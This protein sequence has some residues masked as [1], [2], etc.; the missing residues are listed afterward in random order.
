MSNVKMASINEAME[1]VTCQQA[2]P[3]A[4]DDSNA[5]SRKRPVDCWTDDSDRET[6]VLSKF[7]GNKCS[8]NTVPCSPP[9]S[10]KTIV[11]DD[12]SNGQVSEHGEHSTNSSHE[13]GLLEFMKDGTTV[14]EAA[15]LAS[16]AT[17]IDNVIRHFRKSNKP[18]SGK[19]L[20]TMKKA[21]VTK[22]K[23]QKLNNGIETC[24]NIKP[25]HTSDQSA[26]D[27]L[28]KCAFCHSIEI[29]DLTGPMLHYVDGQLVEEDQPSQP[30]AIHVHQKCFDWAPQV[31]YVG[32]KIVNLEAE[33]SRASKLKCSKCGQK[34]AALGC[35]LNKCRR[36]YHVPC[37]VQ[38]QD[39]RWDCENYL[40]LCP[41][42]TSLRLPCDASKSSGMKF[43]AN[44][45][46]PSQMGPSAGL[47]SERIL[48]GSALS[49]EE[50]ELIDKFANFFGMAV[51]KTWD[52]IVTH[53]IAS[54]NDEGACS[55]TFKV[56]MAILCGK[57]VL[58]INWV[59]ACM[60]AG[61]LIP[62]EPYEISLDIYGCSDGPKTG[63]LR[64]LQKLPKLFTGSSFYFSGYFSPSL[65][66]NLEA[67][68]IIAGGT[69]LDKNTIPVS[70]DSNSPQCLSEIYIVYNADPP[71]PNFSWDPA[72]DVRKR[73]QDAEA[74]AARIS[75]QREV[76]D[77][78]IESDNTQQGRHTCLPALSGPDDLVSISSGIVLRSIA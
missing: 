62:E 22:S 55:R 2:P 50:K 72:E 18:M 63:R 10:P 58:N 53:V 19:T 66:R 75:G 14:K 20:S 51:M 40:M 8:I 33:I 11:V 23:K 71:E 46:S 41:S 1:V 37:A 64:I 60:E 21:N 47:S 3:V 45:P 17:P 56:L 54:T 28:V 24:S 35:F 31:Y 61:K 65:Q 78:S 42:H 25:S 77:W 68:I 29:T 44:R 43:Q 34:G 26:A 4:I 70:D 67:L 76:R 48:C 16:F 36:S 7:G 38:V 59:K 13:K 74:L 27:G 69:I 15:A 30:N 9:H 12:D 6:E 32:N 39:C 73:L 52:H 5:T 49:E 57:W